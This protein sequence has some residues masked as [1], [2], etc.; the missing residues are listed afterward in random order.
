MLG[1]TGNLDFV[2]SLGSIRLMPDKR[3][4]QWTFSDAVEEAALS[5]FLC[6]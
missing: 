4:A 3:Q 1:V 6:N 5:P 2:S